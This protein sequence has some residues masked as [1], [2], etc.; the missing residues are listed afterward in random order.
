MKYLG[1]LGFAAAGSGSVFIE[2]YNK[3][4]AIITVQ[5][6]AEKIRSSQV[7]YQAIK[8]SLSQNNQKIF[9]VKIQVFPEGTRNN[10]GSLLPF[11]KGAF[12][13]AIQAKVNQLEVF[14]FLVNE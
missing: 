13:L 7:E 2:R 14:N 12:H 11:K 5:K 8:F 3:E 10:D 4:S 6:A 9:Q 1:L